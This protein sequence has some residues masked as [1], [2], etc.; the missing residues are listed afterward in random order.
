MAY[1]EI[2]TESYR[3]EIKVSLREFEFIEDILHFAFIFSC[4][5]WNKPR[6]RAWHNCI[7]PP[8]EQWVGT[9]LHN[10]V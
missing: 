3:K 7:Q 2:M 8:A 1:S 5:E 10:H 6:S 4:F 9:I